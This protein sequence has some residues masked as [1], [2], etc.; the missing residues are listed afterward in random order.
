MSSFNTS[1]ISNASLKSELGLLGST[2]MEKSSI[3]G[4]MI[5]FLLFH[6]LIIS[7]LQ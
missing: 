6:L 4:S 2:L 7:F 3:L 5:D 1:Q